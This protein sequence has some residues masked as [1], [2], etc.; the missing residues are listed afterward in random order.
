[1]SSMDEIREL[2]RGRHLTDQDVS[3]L[4]EQGHDEDEILQAMFDEGHEIGLTMDFEN[5]WWPRED[6]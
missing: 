5:E 2:V 4:V 3:R 1:M 6:E